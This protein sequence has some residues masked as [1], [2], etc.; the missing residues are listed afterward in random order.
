MSIL[1]TTP[2]ESMFKTIAI[3]IAVLFAALLAYAATKPDTFRVQRATSIKAPPEKIFALINDLHSWNAWSPYEKKDPAMKR[4]HS[5]AANGKGAVYAW[6][7]NHE[8]G[9][10]S[11]EITESS[12]PSKVAIKLDFIKPFEGHNT[13]EF[14]LEPKGDSTNVTWA[15]Y[16]PTPYLAKIIH[17]FF[18][19][20]N[21]VGKDFEAGL[22]SLK[23]A[24]E[25]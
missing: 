19:M 13:A 16:G 22:A 4:T 17:V 2:E 14:T 6:E 25:K 15:M 10:G 23:T 18:D 5:G 7:G 8:I 3:V 20:D 1:T 11:M 9:M 12:P 24:A 21:M